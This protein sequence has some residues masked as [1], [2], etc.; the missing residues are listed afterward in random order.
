MAIVVFEHHP[1]ESTLRLGEVLRDQGH[2]LRVIKLYEGGEVPGDFDDVDGLIVMGGPMNVDETDKYD[3]MQPEIDYIKAAHEKE[4]PVIG[5]CLGA[6]LIAVALGG[7]V[8]KMEKPEVGIS[9][10]TESFFG[11]VDTLLSGLPWDTPQFHIHGCEV[12][13]AP[14][15]GT[16]L[17]LSSTPA[18]KIQAFKVGFTTYGFQYHFECTRD[19]IDAWLT[20]ADNVAWLEG[21]GVDLAAV[22]A[23][24]E[25]HYD[26]YRHLGDRLCNNIATLCFPLDKRMQPRGG[27]VENFHAS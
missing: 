9:P 4:L 7:E 21:A 11:T 3:W 8:A 17:P 26:M 12:T 18:C 19:A 27:M 16:P 5:V 24:V 2:K 6:Q 25:E 20:D 1:L 14:A 13:Q 15:G 23:S 10:V 22:K